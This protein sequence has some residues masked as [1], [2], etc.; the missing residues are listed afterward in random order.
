MEK[1]IH[2]CW[3]GKGELPENARKCIE[4]WKVNFPG[5]VIK[6]WNEDNFDIDDTCIYVKQAYDQKK[7]AFVSDYARFKILYE[8]GGFYFDTDVEVL[9]NME[10]L[11]A[12]CDCFMGEEIS[13][14]HFGT[15]LEV[16]PG[17]GMYAKAGNR[18]FNEIIEYYDT[19]KFLDESGNFN[20]NTVVD[21]TTKIMKKH[22]F[23]GNG[24]IEKIQDIKIYPPEY[25]CPMNPKTGKIKI[26][27]TTYSIH[28]Y[29][30]SWQSGYSR[31]KTKIQRIIGPN[32]TKM[33]ISLKKKLK[34]VNKNV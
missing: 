14:E 18:I 24:N 15:G 11:V 6:E 2:Y 19:L 17:L 3:F 7:W 5:Y 4:S 20:G 26:T 10:D 31:F 12:D 27:K 29:T 8:Y 9:R 30:A 13:D 34:S 21:Y 33:I 32:L 1:I 23:V 16:N 25:F 28:H 22:G